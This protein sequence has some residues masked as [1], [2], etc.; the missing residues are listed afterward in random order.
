MR[1]KAWEVACEAGTAALSLKPMERVALRRVSS[2]TEQRERRPPPVIAVRA[3]AIFCT[4]SPEEKPADEN[5]S[6]RG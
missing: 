5:P 1:P 4:G 6:D 2:A 3:L